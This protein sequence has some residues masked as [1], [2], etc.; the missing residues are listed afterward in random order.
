M[1][2][3]LYT[4]LQDTFSKSG[5]G[6]A[7]Y[8]QE[9]A[10]N[11]VGQPYTLDKS[12]DFDVLHIN[13]YL[14]GSYFLAWKSREEGKAVVYHAH[15][16]EED[17]RNSFLFSNQVAPLFKKWI[18][19]AYELGDVIVTPT[20]YSKRLLQ[21]YGIDKEIYTISNGINLNDFQA[22]PYAREEF[23]RKWDYDPS[24]KIVMGIGLYLER[25]GILDFVEL[26]RRMTD[27]QFI[28][29]GYTKPNLIP[30][31][32]SDAIKTQLPNLRFPGYVPNADIRLGLQA[33]DVYLFP[34]LEET[35][36]IPA[37]EA[38][39]SKARMIVRDIPVFEGW[40]EDGV[41]CYKARDLDGFEARIRQLLNG[42]VPDLGEAAY[43]VAVARDI[44]KV[45]A[46]LQ[47]VYERAMELRDRR[48]GAESDA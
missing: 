43:E 14:P 36:G 47:R 28:W 24:Q 27:V 35:E 31:R 48:V 32:V 17:F 44:P 13:T 16:T 33:T 9:E 41:N 6:R 11:A 37:V 38:C 15:S 5:L 29:F 8:H 34:T 42:E 3:L 20:P 10:L 21:G 22:I 45:G 2:V 7:I 39:A 12:E 25:K 18:T 4:E 23:C 46:A 26:A 19:K 1:K 40:L 30:Q